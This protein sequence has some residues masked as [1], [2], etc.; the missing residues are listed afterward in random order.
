MADRSQSP[1]AKRLVSNTKNNLLLHLKSSNWLL[2]LHF[3]IKT[4]NRSTYTKNS[5]DATSG[6]ALRKKATAG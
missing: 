5:K 6:Q 2:E 1:K 3:C 4:A